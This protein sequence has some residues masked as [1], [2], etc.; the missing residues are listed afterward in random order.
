MSDETP[1]RESPAADD[2]LPAV[3]PDSERPDEVQR[4]VSDMLAFDRTELAHERTF[5]AYLRTGLTFLMAGL[6][7][8]KLFEDIG[9][10]RLGQLFV[11]VGVVV[12]AFGIWRLRKLRYL[13][14]QR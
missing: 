11:F 5:L 10:V 6:T 7:L 14:L 2:G 9:A 4:S 1:E 13:R 8:I 12:F 3:L